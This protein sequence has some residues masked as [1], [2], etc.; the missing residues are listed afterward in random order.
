MEDVT[1]FMIVVHE[2]VVLFQDKSFIATYHTLTETFDNSQDEYFD[3]NVA[4]EN[5]NNFFTMQCEEIVE[6]VAQDAD[7]S[8]ESTEEVNEEAAEETVEE[9]LEASDEEK[10][11]KKHI[12]RNVILGVLAAAVLAVGILFYNYYYLQ[13]IDLMTVTGDESSVSV[14][15]DTK[16]DHSKLNVICAD[17]YG[18]KTTSPVVDGKAT[19]PN[20]LGGT[21]Y[22]ITVTMDGF[23]KVI[24]DSKKTYF[25]PSLTNIIQFSAVTGS[26]NGSVNLNFAVDGPDSAQ[27]Q[28]SYGPADEEPAVLT[29]EGHRA[30]IKGLTVG[31]EYTIKLSSVDELYL[32]GD[33]EL[34]HTASD[35]IYPENVAITSFK[36]KLLTVNWTAPENTKN[37]EWYVHCYNTAGYNETI[38][39]KDLTATFEN[40]DNTQD[41][42]VE[43]SASGQS[44]FQRTTVEEN[45]I[46]LDNIS[47]SL[48][49]NGQIALSWNCSGDIPEGGWN[50]ICAIDG[51]EFTSTY[52][53]DA[54]QIVILDT[55]PENDYT[56]NIEAVNGAPVVCSPIQI[57]SGAA[58]TFSCDFGG[59]PISGN[60][61]SLS[62]CVTPD[63]ENWTRNDLKKADYT[64]NFKVGQNASFVIRA[65]KLYGI[66]DDELIVTY[67]I[68]DKD[69]KLISVQNEEFTWRTLWDYYYGE[70]N[71]P[72][73]P[74]VAGEYTV[75]IY[76]NSGLVDEQPFTISE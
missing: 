76:F 69:G 16:I 42:T 43:I 20:L 41:Y 2:Q 27:W 62:M 61:I 24:G 46:T 3:Q 17:I 34:S 51:T 8:E 9:D 55:L 26:E 4:F 65:L 60:E 22:T 10:P 50:V 54:N 66:S 6:P 52:T 18:T 35:L 23:H 36:D 48:N 59:A 39:T 33:L 45:S 73:L 13:R 37:E 32:S 72:S 40:I 12:L 21:E 31:K 49:E 71:I 28:V 57:S 67:A 53:C 68:T 30:T 14:V 70:I 58:K 11:P 38:A 44:V 15:I 1:A 56:I 74:S 7:A 75:T 29:F 47:A 19:F 5:A 63:K 64:T 25:T